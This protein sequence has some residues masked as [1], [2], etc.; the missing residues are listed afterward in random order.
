MQWVIAQCWEVT[1]SYRGSAMCRGQR[2]SLCRPPP[3]PLTPAPSRK[4]GFTLV[5]SHCGA[6]CEQNSVRN[7]RLCNEENLR[8]FWTSLWDLLYLKWCAGSSHFHTVHRTNARFRFSKL[9]LW[10][11][12]HTQAFHDVMNEWITPFE[13]QCWVFTKQLIT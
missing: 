8:S 6:K 2:A 1:P 12:K 13:K 3:K 7:C 5:L 9:Q 10:P 11:H 4:C